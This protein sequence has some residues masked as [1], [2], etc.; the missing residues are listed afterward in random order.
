[1]RTQPSEG[2]FHTDNC[3]T[4]AVCDPWTQDDLST[5]NHIQNSRLQKDSLRVFRRIV[6]DAIFV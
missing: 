6:F 2:M 1:M 3:V 5:K 4:K